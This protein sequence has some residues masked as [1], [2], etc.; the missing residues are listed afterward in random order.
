MGYGIIDI[1]SIILENENGE[2][3]SKAATPKEIGFTPTILW[4]LYMMFSFSQG[5]NTYLEDI[6]YYI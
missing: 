3:L 6:I 1:Y 5:L 4:I 2:N